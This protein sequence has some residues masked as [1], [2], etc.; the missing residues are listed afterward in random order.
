MKKQKIWQ[1][2]SICLLLAVALTGCGG[3]KAATPAEGKKIK[4]IATIYPVYE[5][6]KQVGGDKIDVSMLIPPGAEP[7]DWEPTA[8]E[9]GKIKTAKLFLYHGAGLEPVDKL[10]Q[11]EVL[12]EAKAVEVSKDIHKL[13]GHEEAGHEDKHKH[14]HEFDA[15]VW[16]D[17]VL[18]QQEVTKIAEAL[19]EADAANAAYYKANAEAYNKQLAELDQEYKKSLAGIVRK[20]IV[21]SHTAFG[22]LAQRY[23]LKQ[24]GIMGLSP[25]S[26]PT[27]EKMAEIT[28]FCR[29]HKVKYIFAETIANSKLADTLAKEAGAQ[30]L[31]LNPLENLTDEELKQGKTYISVMR[32]N[33]V[34]LEKALK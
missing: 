8:K 19:A 4:V 22:Y 10:L 17:P 27:P 29:E 16:L 34:Q 32:D 3:N 13:S 11:K 21:T 28:K 5:F 25:D 12:G 24:L 1:I 31:V 6:A 33:L 23:E 2:V 26:E 7:H 9:L 30:I 14:E 18:A 15:H 20:E